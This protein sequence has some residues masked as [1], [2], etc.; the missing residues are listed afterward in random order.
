TPAWLESQS[1]T[2]EELRQVLREHVATAVSRYQG[3]VQLWDVVN[4]AIDEDGGRRQSLWQRVIGDDYIELAFRWA[5]EA[6][7]KAVLLYNDF[8][9]EGLGRKSDAI[10]ELLRDLKNRGVPIHGVGL[11]MHMTVGK[12]PP[13][14]EFRANLQRLADLGP[15]VA[16]H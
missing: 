14:K 7:P 16:C 9:G 13:Q 6:D 12:I 1:W 8:N 11:Q 2:R 4:E 15:G 5:H 10:Y 3:R